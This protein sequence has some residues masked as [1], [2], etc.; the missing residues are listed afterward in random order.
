ML[1]SGLIF[2]KINNMTITWYGQ[3]CFRIETKGASSTGLGQAS[4]LIDPF[5]RDIGLRP[6]RIKDDIVLV[7]HA[8]YD[9]NNL[10][11]LNEEA[12]VINTPGEYER[13][14][15]YVR[16][17]R[18]YHDNSSGIERGLNTVFILK[19]EDM[20][21]CHMGDFGQTKLEEHQLEE[22]GDVD[23]LMIPVGGKYTIGSKEAVEI[24]GQIEP[25]IVIPM[26]YKVPSLN[27]D[28]DGP[29]KFTKEL[30]LAPEKVDKFKIAKKLLP[31]EE[32]KLVMFEL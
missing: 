22:I 10:E 32:I 12:F 30:G 26:H 11:G 2:D 6:P 18:S 14:G 3:S 31:A 23:L 16:G 28:I 21:I 20:A 1:L 25:K 7:T 9:H 29:E 19:A 27:I 24:I 17:T 4:V 5:S 15:I 13:K 8:H